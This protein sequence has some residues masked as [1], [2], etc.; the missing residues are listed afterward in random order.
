MKL[1]NRTLSFDILKIIAC[2]LVILNHTGS[3]LFQY[4]STSSNFYLMIYSFL[5]TLSKI[6][7][8][9]FIMI[10]GSLLL[11][12]EYTYKDLYRDKLVRILCPLI[13][14]SFIFYG[15]NNGFSFTNIIPFFKNFLANPIILPY[16]YL[17]ML[18]GLYLITP[19]IK[20]MIQNFKEKDYKIFLFLFLF[21]PGCYFLLNPYL[22]NQPLSSY[23]YGAT[24]SS[25]IGYYI[26]GYYLS[27]CETTKEKNRFSIVMF[28]LSISMTALFMYIITKLSMNNISYYFDN[29]LYITTIVPATC[30]F[31]STIHIFKNKTFPKKIT[32]FVSLLASLTFGIY[33]FHVFSINKIWNLSIIQECFQIEPLFGLIALIAGNF[34]VCGIITFIL[35]KIP[36]I[37]KYL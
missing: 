20:K 33:L 7:V 26:L 31:Y 35:K 19:F 17:Y 10:S 21:L 23:F 25:Y 6:A 3:F 15:M 37:Q 32:Q 14:L 30:I 13:L 2:L 8:P 36:I 29:P 16:W 11:K 24:F 12:K 18:T 5:F 4:V 27:N 9:I 1:H 28:L 34:L 22:Y